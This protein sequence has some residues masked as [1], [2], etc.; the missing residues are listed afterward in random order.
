VARLNRG[1]GRRGGRLGNK[2][3]H[4]PGI[5]VRRTGFPRARAPAT[6]GAPTGTGP[7][8]MRRAPVRAVP[9]GRRGNGAAWPALPYRIGRASRRGHPPR[10]G[11]AIP[12]TALSGRPGERRPYGPR[13]ERGVTGLRRRCPGISPGAGRTGSPT[14]C[15]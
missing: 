12:R 7:G 1:P 14:R 6:A 10:A 9:A 3:G 2:T 8:V 5:R 13:R 11:T 4:A 15:N